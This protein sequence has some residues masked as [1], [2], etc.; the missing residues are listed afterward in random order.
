M[1]AMPSGPDKFSQALRYLQ[2]QIDQLRATRAPDMLT[3]NTTNGVS[4]R[5]KITAR[6]SGSSTDDFPVNELSVCVKNADG[7]TREGFVRG[8]FTQVFF[9]DGSGSPVDASGNPVEGL[10]DIT[11]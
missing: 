2:G 5:P 4:R 9:K 6:T 11:G 1:Y 3:S 8:R 7:T 10:P